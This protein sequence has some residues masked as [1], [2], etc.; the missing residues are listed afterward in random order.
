MVWGAL[1][2]MAWIICTFVEGLLMLKDI[3]TGFSSTYAAKQ[4]NLFLG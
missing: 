2:Q 4:T 1:M 3:N